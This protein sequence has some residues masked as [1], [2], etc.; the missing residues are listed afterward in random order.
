MA[1]GRTAMLPI[2]H[3]FHAAHSGREWLLPVMLIAGTGTALLARWLGRMLRGG[4]DDHD[5]PI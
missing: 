3:G 4:P 2:L 5:E 1:D